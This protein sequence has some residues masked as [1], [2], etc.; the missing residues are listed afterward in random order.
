MKVNITLK[1]KRIVVIESE[2]VMGGTWI[3]ES[4]SF[5]EGCIKT[6]NADNERI[7]EYLK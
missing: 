5:V 1:N 2:E 3:N 7:L 4:D 6:I